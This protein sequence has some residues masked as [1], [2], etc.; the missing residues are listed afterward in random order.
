MILLDAPLGFEWRKG[1]LLTVLQH[2]MIF[3]PT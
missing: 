3:N 2:E 1:L